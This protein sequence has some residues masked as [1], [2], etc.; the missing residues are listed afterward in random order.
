MSPKGFSICGLGVY[1]TGGT[2]V[3]LR[4]TTQFSAAVFVY[5]ISQGDRLNRIG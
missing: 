5:S 1:S 3:Y 2:A 4:H